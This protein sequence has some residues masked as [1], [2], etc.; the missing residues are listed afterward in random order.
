MRLGRGRPTP[1]DT[2]CRFL[3]HEGP[4]GVRRTEIGSRQGSE[5]GVGTESQSGKMKSSGDRDGDGG[6]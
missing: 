4:R 1:K 2:P 3:S 6:G 5:C